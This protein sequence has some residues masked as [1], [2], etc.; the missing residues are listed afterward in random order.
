[1]L[2]FEVATICLS[3]CVRIKQRHKQLYQPRNEAKICALD[4]NVRQGDQKGNSAL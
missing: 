3:T 4:T 1:M 2:P